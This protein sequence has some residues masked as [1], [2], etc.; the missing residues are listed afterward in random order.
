MDWFRNYELFVGL[1][2]LKRTGWV[3]RYAPDES[4]ADHVAATLF[5]AEV[6]LPTF[7]VILDASR[8]YRMLIWHEFAERITG[9]IPSIYKKVQEA[10]AP[11]EAEF[12]LTLA[13]DE[14]YKLWD[15][16]H[17][18]SSKEAFFARFIDKLEP[19]LQ[20]LLYARYGWNGAAEFK[21]SLIKWIDSVR[22]KVSSL[23]E[24]SEK[25]LA[26]VESI[27]SKL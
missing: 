17:T 23:F 21:N 8:V 14:I 19:V 15:E 5:L 1:K 24:E 20:A 25:V 9:D 22:D 11:V 3:L 4:I 26:W 18:V 7:P 10:I 12:V 2:R 16:F 6:L 27:V 13:G